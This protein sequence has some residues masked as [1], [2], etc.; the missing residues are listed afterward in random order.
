[1]KPIHEMNQAEIAA[2]VQTELRKAN[3]YVV[4]SGGAVVGIYSK[5]DYVS[6]DIDLVNSGFSKREKI[7]QVMTTLG[8]H[9]VGRHYE[10]PNSNQIIEFPPGP[11]TLGDDP[12]MTTNQ[13][14]YETGTLETLTPT[15]CVKDRLAHYYHW[16]DN[17]CLHQAILV[18]QNYD[19]DI[20]DI[21]MWSEEEGHRDTFTK[22]KNQLKTK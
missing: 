18:A 1:M 15:D 10:H 5:G 21:D 17:Q 9:S 4:L 8:F 14:Y 13:L 3:I 2:Y 20:K 22:I 7:E 6:K 19:I 16:G 11:L 12:V